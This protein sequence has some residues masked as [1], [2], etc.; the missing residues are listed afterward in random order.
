MHRSLGKSWAS[1]DFANNRLLQGV[2]LWL[3]AVWLWAAWKPVDRF[4]W[5]LENLLVFIYGVILAVT[6]RRFTFSNLSY[7]LFAIFLTLHL[8]GAH[9]TYAQTPVGFWM[10]DVF[11]LARNHYDRVVH[12][13]YGLLLA[14]PFREILLRKSGLSESWTP[15]MVVVSILAFSAFFEVI[16]ALIAALVSP[17]QGDAYLGTQ[18]D[19]WDAQWD[20]GLATLG[21]AI[22]M[23]VTRWLV[24]RRVLR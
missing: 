22:A 4:D 5:F 14:Y 3:A 10:R 2:L 11:D 12:F 9:Y 24:A 20:M 1:A 16:E 17:E 8:I 18:G 13:S 15:F 6:Y 21:A 7:S 23:G 19:I